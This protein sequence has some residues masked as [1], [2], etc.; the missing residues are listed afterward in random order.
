MSNGSSPCIF[1][2]VETT[3][4]AF[5]IINGTKCGVSCGV[6]PVFDLFYTNHELDKLRRIIFLL[7]LI[8]TSLVPIY[9]S[10]AVLE[11][12]R[13]P[14]NFVGVPFA[15]Q[16][17]FFISSGYLL[18]AFISLSPFI[19]G[20]SK[21][22]CNNDEH[23]ITLD[24]FS[25]VPCTLT[26]IGMHIGIRVALF[27]TCALSVS[28]AL[29]LY[30]PRYKQP[31]RYYHF[32]AWTITLLGIVPIQIKKTISGDLV[33]GICTTSLHSKYDLLTLDII[34]L[35]SCILIFSIC[36][37]V[38]AIKVSR[39]NNALSKLLEVN[40]DIRSLF[41]RL[42]VYNILQTSAVAVVVGNFCYWYVNLDSWEQTESSVIMCEVE[43]T[44]TNQTST[45]NFDNCVGDYAEQSRPTFG[46]YCIFQSCALISILGAIIFQCSLRV[47]KRSLNSI[48]NSLLL[49]V[50]SF[51]SLTVSRRNEDT[52]TS[53]MLSSDADLVRTTKY[54]TDS[55]VLE[56]FTSNESQ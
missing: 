52:F 12:L 53:A 5:Q 7:S 39:Q 2:L 48:R 15:Y 46:A 34:P 17:P 27:Y 41:H 40:K 35:S 29:T 19:F 10:T 42:L 49:L 31:K 11:R 13:A 21:I 22:I 38:A 43:L 44:L 16:C 47:Q 45:D 20:P 37:G 1:P 36:L 18:V 55:I 26:A 50:N 32:V 14:N 23:T 25:N 9:V 54:T 28:L 30:H 4:A 56:N 6:T 8:T 51:R 24:T 33:L 3:Y